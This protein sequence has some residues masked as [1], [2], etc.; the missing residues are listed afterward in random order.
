MIN[1]S[2]IILAIWLLTFH[3]A[4]TYVSSL[5][6]KNTIPLWLFTFQD[7]SKVLKRT[8]SEQG[9]VP[10]TW[11]KYSWHPWVPDHQNENSFR[12]VGTFSFALCH[13]YESLFRSWDNLAS[14]LACFLC[15]APTLVMN[16]SLASKFRLGSKFKW[17][18]D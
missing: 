11:F 13:T 8:Q 12:N 18:W 9:I 2:R 3:M 10:K 14:L 16:S 5:C 17:E 1:G 6:F 4:I 7:Y 15:H